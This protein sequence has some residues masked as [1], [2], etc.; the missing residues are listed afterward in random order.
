MRFDLFEKM[1]AEEARRTLEEFLEAGKRQE[2]ESGFNSDYSL[3]K[4]PELLEC[5]SQKLTSI[6][7]KEDP[8]VPEY[9]RNTDEY[10]SGL[11]EFSSEATQLIIGAAYHFGECFIRSYSRLQWGLGNVKYATG[12][13]PV[14]AGFEGSRELPV[15]LVLVNLFERRIENPQLQNIFCTAI[16]NWKGYA[17]LAK[18]TT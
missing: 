7:C 18:S 13:M 6:P 10:Q 4:L 14:V 15:L 8:S 3:S 17:S 5:I 1:F 16:D 9:I 2:L 12:N 11:Y